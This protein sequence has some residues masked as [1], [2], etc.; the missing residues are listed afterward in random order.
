MSTAPKASLQDVRTNIESTIKAIQE[1]EK[2]IQENIGSSDKSAEDMMKHALDDYVRTLQDM[3]TT[4]SINVVMDEG[5]PVE[6]PLDIVE[7]I[8]QGKN[9]DEWMR[10]C[11]SSV[12]Q[13]AQQ[14]KGK[15]A[16]MHMLNDTMTL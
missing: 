6:V 10:I 13:K 2:R 16:A 7:F 12:L 15:S 5:E 11:M 14:A 3:Y 4:A 9:P 1:I 8:D